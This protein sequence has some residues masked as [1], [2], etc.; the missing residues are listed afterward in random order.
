[1]AGLGFQIYKRTSAGSDVKEKMPSVASTQYLSGGGS[2]LTTMP[3]SGNNGFANLVAAADKGTHIYE[4]MITPD[5]VVAQAVADKSTAL[6]ENVLATPV[7]GRNILKSWLVGD[8]VPPINKVACNTNANK[9]QA[10]VTAAG[11]TGDYTNGTIYIPE[12]GE[13]RTITGDAVGGGVHT[14]T[15]LPAFV[16]APTVGHTAIVVAFSKGSSAVKFNATSPSQCL[17]TA[18][19]DKTGGHN[20]IEDVS[21]AGDNF[22]PFVLSSCPDLQ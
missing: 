7:A 16:T 14:F 15:V 11:S 10:L 20:K 4:S 12:T 1:M 19:A 6:S 5:S 3:A 9:G 8:A 17:G 21:L 18:V 22:G 2:M 13:Q